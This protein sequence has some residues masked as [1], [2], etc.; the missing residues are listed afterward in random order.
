[1]V[2]TLFLAELV[3]TSILIILGVGVC[4]GVSL[5]NQSPIIVDGL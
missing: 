3:G 5:K 1:M 2:M 4:A